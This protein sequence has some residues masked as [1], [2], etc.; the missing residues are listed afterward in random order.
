MS[1]D[2]SAEVGDAILMR[3]ARFSLAGLLGA[4]VV[5]AVG[6]ACLMFAST[7]WA[8]VVWSVTLGFLTLAPLG[9]IYRRGERRAHWAGVV[10][11]GWAYMTLSS[12]P[13]F[14]NF[15]RHRLVTSRLL[16]WAYPWLIPADHQATNPRFVLRPFFLPPVAF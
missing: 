14:I 9:I 12:G 6:M 5:F 16:E 13:W 2:S 8:G 7:A 10:L 3:F 15:I 1:D 4:I 11:C